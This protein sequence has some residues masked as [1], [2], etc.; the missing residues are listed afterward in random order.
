M[1]EMRIL[2]D[3]L[4]KLISNDRAMQWSRSFYNNN[5]CQYVDA[6]YLVLKDDVEVEIFM[7]NELDE[8][9]HLW[10][11]GSA[12]QPGFW[13]D[14]FEKKEDALSLCKDMGWTIKVDD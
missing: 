14:A 7:S 9:K 10:V 4:V 11:V 12:E 6:L 13:L 8:S 3:F 5:K 2:C 1:V